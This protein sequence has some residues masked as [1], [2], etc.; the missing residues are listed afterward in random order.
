VRKRRVGVLGSF[1]WDVIY[2][3]DVRVAPVEEWGGVT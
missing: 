3:R 1:V 2:G